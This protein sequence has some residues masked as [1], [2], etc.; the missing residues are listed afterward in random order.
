GDI[1][2]S[3]PTFVGAPSPN[4]IPDTFHDKL[5]GTTGSE[6]GYSAYVS[7]HEDRVGVAYV[8]ANDGFLHGFRAS[9]GH[10]L[11][12]YMPRNVLTKKAIHL[13]SPLYSHDYLVDATPVA[14]DV[15]YNSKWHTWL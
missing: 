10:E 11:L 3:S 14:G 9:D 4:V 8:G 5:H 13:S 12:G 15:Y 2:N 7:S 6:S 1:I